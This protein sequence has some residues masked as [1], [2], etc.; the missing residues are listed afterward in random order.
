MIGSKDQFLSPLLP[1]HLQR[2]RRGVERLLAQLRMR[3]RD[4]HDRI[5]EDLLWLLHLVVR[6][7]TPP[8][9]S[10]RLPKLL[11]RIETGTRHG[12]VKPIRGPSMLSECRH[13]FRPLPF[14]DHQGAID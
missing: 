11:E 6:R 8:D 5:S 10:Q 7:E 13:L 3:L 4:G 14:P 9:V 12:L 2:T 1:N